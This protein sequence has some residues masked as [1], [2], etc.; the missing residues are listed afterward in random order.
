MDQTSR[1]A[2]TRYND[3]ASMKA[4]EYAYW[5]KQPVHVRMKAVSELTLEMYRLK[6]TAVD[7]SG[8]SKTLVRL[9]RP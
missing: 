6:G 1:F 4:D 5:Q 2:I 7:V 3:L 8:L 9:E